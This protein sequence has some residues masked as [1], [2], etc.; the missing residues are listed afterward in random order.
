[1][2]SVPLRELLAV[3]G[4]TVMLTLAA[5]VPLAPLA[6]VIQ[7][8]SERAVHEQPLSVLTVIAREPPDACIEMVVAESV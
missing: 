6:I 4:D 1:M 7:L 5:P 2:V 8:A 3:F